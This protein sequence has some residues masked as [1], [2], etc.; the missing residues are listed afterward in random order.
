[1]TNQQNIL[2]CALQLFAS[3]G[4]DAVGVQ[5]IVLQAGITK[6]T[7][8]YYF[9]NKRGLLEAIMKEYSAKLLIVVTKASIYNGDITK[10]LTDVASTYF[11]FAVKYPDFFRL[12]LSLWLAPPDSKPFQV[13]LPYLEL[14]QRSIEEIFVNAVKD[15]GNMKGRHII[16]ALSFL[17]IIHTYIG[18]AFNG[19]TKLNNELV[20]KL[21]HQFMHG[22]FS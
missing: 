19:Y 7:M 4:Y 2:A 17:G 14:E 15:H 16:Y 1:M 3:K 20:H 11:D 18:V 12:Q 9:E 5:E 22:I 8:Y 13:I 6:P 21:I 10:T